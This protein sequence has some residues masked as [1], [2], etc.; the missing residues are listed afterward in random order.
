MVYPV[1]SK[2]NVLIN[3][4]E[5]FSKEQKRLRQRPLCSSCSLMCLYIVDMC[6]AIKKKHV[7]WR[8]ETIQI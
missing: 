4:V 8:K 2:I 7:S 1:K 6:Q 5:L 3:G